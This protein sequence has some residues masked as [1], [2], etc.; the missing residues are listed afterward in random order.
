[1]ICQLLIVS[2]D[3]LS[4]AELKRK[5]PLGHVAGE[6]SCREWRKAT[7][8]FSHSQIQNERVKNPY[9]DLNTQ[10]ERVVQSQSSAVCVL[11]L[12]YQVSASVS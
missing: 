10:R 4:S 11:E 8:A 1:M 3:F 6:S 9:I 5:V 12:E 7:S 2:L